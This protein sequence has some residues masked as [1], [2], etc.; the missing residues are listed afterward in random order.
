MEVIEEE[1]GREKN[2][3][4]LIICSVRGKKNNNNNQIHKIEHP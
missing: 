2:I 4:A 3:L 1:D